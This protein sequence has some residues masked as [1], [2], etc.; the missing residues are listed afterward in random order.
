LLLLHTDKGNTGMAAVWILKSHLDCS[1]FHFRDIFH[2]E[3]NDVTLALR[4][5]GLYWTILLSTVVYNLCFG[6]WEG[7]AWFEKLKAGAEEYFKKESVARPLFATLYQLICRDRGCPPVGTF[8]HREAVLKQTASAEGFSKKG[9]R[10][11]LKRWFSWVAAT[12]FH[13]QE[14][15]SRLCVILSIGLQLGIYKS[16]R[17]L[18][19]WGGPAASLDSTADDQELHQDHEAATLLEKVAKKA[20]VAASSSSKDTYQGEGSTLM[21]KRKMTP[22]RASGSRAITPCVWP[23]GSCAE[24]ASGPWSRPSGSLLAPSTTATVSM[25]PLSAALPKRSTSTSRQPK[26]TGSQHCNRLAQ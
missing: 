24:K 20:A 9:P 12:D 22:S 10:A 25:Q 5:C 8:E 2:R 16:W 23:A 21:H 1:F 7:S 6:P 11:T 14:W 17:E 13:T 15:H 4:R 26:G 3:W 18:P 19:L